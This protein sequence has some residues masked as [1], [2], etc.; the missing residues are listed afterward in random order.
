MKFL[1]D[2]PVSPSLLRVLRIYGHEGVHASQIGKSRAADEE[3][4]ELARQEDRTIITADLDFPRLLAL[5]FA[6]GPGIILFRGGNYSDEEMRD[7]LERVFKEV[8]PENL[9]NSI[10][11]VDRQ[12]IR[13]TNLPIDRS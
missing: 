6:A 4:L 1:L 11:V 3:L 10:C 2:M 13:L 8:P 9:K 5:S 7:L 12:R